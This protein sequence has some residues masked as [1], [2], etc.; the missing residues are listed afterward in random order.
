MENHVS[1]CVC[2]CVCVRRCSR[3]WRVYCVWVRSSSSSITGR[4]SSLSVSLSYETATQRRHESLWSRCSDCSGVTFALT[5]CHNVP[6]S[7]SYL[8]TECIDLLLEQPLSQSTQHRWHCQGHGVKD[9]ERNSR[10]YLL[11][12]EQPLSQSTQHRWHCQGHGVK[13]QERNSRIY[14]ALTVASKLS[15][16]ESSWLWHVG[17]IAREGVQ[18]TSGPVDDDTDSWL[19]RRSSVTHS[20]LSRC[21][22]SPRSLMHVLYTLSSSILHMLLSTEL[23]SGEFGVYSW[24]GINSGV[25]FSNNWMVARAWWEF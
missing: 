24:R 5:L 22:I 14:S 6:I 23:K 15:R 1:M 21:F 13:D 16:F 25:S 4:R 19:P 9:Q 18:N 11:L 17:N 20:V 7:I 10:I 3:W 2:V 8:S 12:L